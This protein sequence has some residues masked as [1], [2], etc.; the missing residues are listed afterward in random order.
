MAACAS[1]LIA[2]AAG[3]FLNKGNMSTPTPLK[4]VNF[5]ISW[6]GGPSSWDPLDFDMA[7]NIFAARMLYSTPVE[8]TEDAELTS[9]VLTKY[10]VLNDGKEIQLTVKSDL[11]FEDGSP[12][13]ADDVAFAVARMAY[14]RP[15]FPVIESIVG[16]NEW[17]AQREPLKSYPKGIEVD[18]SKVTIHLARSETRPLFRLT[19]EIFSIIPRRC[20][21]PLTNKLNCERPPESGPYKLAAGSFGN[22]GLTLTRREAISE[23]YYPKK[24]NFQYIDSQRLREFL[25]ANEGLP[26]VAFA[27]DLDY[28][29]AVLSEI[30]AN[31][32]T[33][34][35]AKSWHGMILLN[36]KRGPFDDLNCRRLFIQGFRQTFATLGL[37]NHKQESSIFTALTPGYETADTL[38]TRGAGPETCTLQGQTL[39]WVR[40]GSRSPDFKVAIEATCERLGMRCEEI[41]AAGR[42]LAALLDSDVNLVSSSTGFWPADPL[43]DLQMLFTPNMHPAFNHITQDA[44]LQ[45]AIRA[46]RAGDVGSAQALK[47]INRILFEKA[48]YNVYTHHQYFYVAP[49]SQS[50][51]LRKTSLGLTVPYPW[52]LFSP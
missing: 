40:R 33:F 30:N 36:P 34:P 14:V 22:G 18:G 11:K 38:S 7:N 43:G 37:A 45:T 29:D 5:A 31:Y 50:A 16:L 48:L 42:P 10:E 12:L 4:E 26:T 17:R 6:V 51:S 15:A 47:D 19:L 1:L 41:A 32:A 8:A 13:N 3:L 20:V 39:K 49:K 23:S 21:D 2:G 44:E 24:F 35:V 27:N 46:A 25:D 9:R 52:Q 28:P